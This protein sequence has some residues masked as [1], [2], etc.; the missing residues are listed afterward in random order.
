MKP[1][2]ETIGIMSAK[3]QFTLRLDPDLHERSVKAA[4]AEGPRVSLNSWI[5]EAVR[6]RLE[7]SKRSKA[8]QGRAVKRG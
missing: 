8:K 4:H 6:M 2:V 3:V 1:I 5:E 7:S